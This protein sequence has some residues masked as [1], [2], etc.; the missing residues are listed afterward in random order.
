MR[1]TASQA[2]VE[3]VLVHTLSAGRY[4]RDGNLPAHKPADKRSERIGAE[5]RFLPAHSPEFN[6]IEMTFSKFKAFLE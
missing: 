4:R 2:Y 5:F 6:P 3:Q 1:I